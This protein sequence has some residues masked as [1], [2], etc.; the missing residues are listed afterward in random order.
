MVLGAFYTTRKVPTLSSATLLA[1]SGQNRSVSFIRF[2]GCVDHWNDLPRPIQFEITR[3]GD[4]IEGS[5]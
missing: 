5:A 4:T 2:F 3:R 1:V